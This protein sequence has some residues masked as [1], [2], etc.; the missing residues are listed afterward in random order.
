MALHGPQGGT[1]LVTEDLHNGR[2]FSELTVRNPFC[3]Q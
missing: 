1:E 2:R 3:T